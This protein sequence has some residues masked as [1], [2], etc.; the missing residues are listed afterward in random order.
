MFNFYVVLAGHDMMSDASRATK[1][2]LIKQNPLITNK[3]TKN[4][5]PLESMGFNGK[6]VWRLQTKKKSRRKIASYQK[7]PEEHTAPK[8][9][10][11]FCQSLCKLYNHFLRTL[12]VVEST[13][14]WKKAI[15][16]VKKK[17]WPMFS[18]IIEHAKRQGTT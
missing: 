15:T 4:E 2:M 6:T 13:K 5:G 18:R 7:H 10:K 17:F 1:C 12:E 16:P 11:V 14:L 9:N 3:S 8:Y